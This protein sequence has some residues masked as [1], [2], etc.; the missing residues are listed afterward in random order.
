MTKVGKIDEQ[1]KLKLEQELENRIR[2]QFGNED[3]VIDL[4]KTTLKNLSY[5]YIESST[6]GEGKVEVLD[7][8]LIIKLSE[9]DKMEFLKIK[10]PKVRNS[11]VDF[12]KANSQNKESEVQ[13]SIWVKPL[14]SGNFSFEL[15]TQVLWKNFKNRD[16]KESYQEKITVDYED[17]IDLRNNFARELDNLCELFV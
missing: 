2:S 5:R 6:T 11:L 12:A 14:K 7:S 17:A 10:N 16:G 1:E 13:L 4:L 9:V 8:S 15:G 3:Q